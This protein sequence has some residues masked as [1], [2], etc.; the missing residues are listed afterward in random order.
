MK[1]WAHIYTEI[2]SADE[3]IVVITINCTLQKDM[4]YCKD[5]KQSTVNNQFIYFI[6]TLVNFFFKKV[7]VLISGH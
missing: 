2:C 1:K 6:V 4:T 5:R 3:D 7:T